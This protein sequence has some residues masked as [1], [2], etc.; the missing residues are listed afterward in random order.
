MYWVLWYNDLLLA[1]LLAL[2]LY[3]LGRRKFLPYPTL[4]D[5]QER[6]RE[7][8][9]AEHFSR[10]VVTGVVSARS[11]RVA[12][13][14]KTLKGLRSTP[15]VDDNSKDPDASSTYSGYLAEGVAENVAICENSV[16]A[17][18]EVSAEEADL[19]RFVLRLANAVAD[20][21]ERIKK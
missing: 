17:T 14:L 5:L 1:G 16:E 12:D 10:N 18:E 4:E 2:V 15:R 21:H 13:L 11:V 6:R 3:S 19:I 8:K 9:S 20:L 7:I